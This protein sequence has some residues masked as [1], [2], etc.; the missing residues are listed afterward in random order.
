MGFLFLYI[1]QLF[2]FSGDG[3]VVSFLQVSSESRPRLMPPIN[4]NLPTLFNIHSL[5]PFV[6][7]PIIL[8]ISECFWETADALLDLHS[9]VT[10]VKKSV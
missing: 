5:N 8:V 9:N 4:S 1:F 10:Q 3:R 2:R 7:S 6:K